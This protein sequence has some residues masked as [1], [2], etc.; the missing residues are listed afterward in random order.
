MNV[1]KL[2]TFIPSTTIMKNIAIVLIVVLALIL[3]AIAERNMKYISVAC[4]KHVTELKHN[5]LLFINKTNEVEAASANV[6]K[7][8]QENVV[9]SEKANVYMLKYQQVL[10]K[11][12]ASL[13]QAMK[14]L[15]KKNSRKNK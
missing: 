13:E 7:L 4:A 14:L 10:E 12:N 3:M 8:Q 5:E 11:N 15:T 9:L 6:L 1:L 2:K